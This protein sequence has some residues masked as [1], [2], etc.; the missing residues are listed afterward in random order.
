MQSA[1]RAPS[2]VA[3]HTCSIPLAPRSFHSMAEG[4]ACET[5]TVRSA[6]QSTAAAKQAQRCS[7]LRPV[8]GQSR[9]A[10]ECDR[11]PE[12]ILYTE[13]GSRRGL[14]PPRGTFRAHC[15]APTCAQSSTRKCKAHAKH[16][17]PIGSNGAGS[18][19]VMVRTRGMQGGTS[20]GGQHKRRFDAPHCHTVMH[21]GGQR[22]ASIAPWTP[23]SVREL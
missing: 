10:R 18:S 4:M 19:T 22:A 17:E 16:V 13:E 20:I 8:F 5:R 14:R 21:G 1:W 15:T 9:G 6:E 7:T 3:C 11:T 23:Q 12:P 2:G